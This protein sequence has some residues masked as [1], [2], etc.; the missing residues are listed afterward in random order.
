MAARLALR[1]V[2]LGFGGIQVLDAV[3][4]EVAPSSVFGLVGPNGAG[5]TFL[6]NCISGYYRPS[7]GSILIDDAEVLSMAP[8]GLAR[9]GLARTF[10]HPALQLRATVLENVLLGAHSRLGGGPWRGRFVRRRRFV[11]SGR[12]DRRRWSFLT[13]SGWVGL[14]GSCRGG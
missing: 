7:A 2:S 1:D 12:F 11:A 8:A 3:S 10:Q 5:K 14:G 4:R 6:F 13:G 9:V